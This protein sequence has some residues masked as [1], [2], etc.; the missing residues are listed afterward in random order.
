MLFATFDRTLW[1]CDWILI[2][3]CGRNPWMPK[4]LAEWTAK[5]QQTNRLKS[6]NLKC[7]LLSRFIVSFNVQ[8]PFHRAADPMFDINE[9]KLTF[10]QI[11]FA[12]TVF[13]YFIRWTLSSSTYLSILCNFELLWNAE[14]E[15][16]IK[17]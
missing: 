16:S 5:K 1:S 14:E 8:F 6:S 10:F 7:N 13:F 12:N 3:L 4:T 9:A 17:N 2:R 15:N 11:S